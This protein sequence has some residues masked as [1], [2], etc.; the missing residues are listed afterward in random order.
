MESEQSTTA[1]LDRL[2]G[3]ASVSSESNLDIVGWIEDYLSQYG[4][5]S[6]RIP[7]RTGRKASILATIGPGDRPGVVLSAHTDVVPV[8]G[9]NWSTPPFTATRRDNRIIGRGATDMK[10]F[11]ASVLAHV[12]QFKAAATKTPI[13]IALSYDEEVGCRGAPD[14]VAEIASAPVRPA[15]CL[16]G[17]P[18]GLAVCYAHKGKVARHLTITGR[19]GHSALPHRG[20]NAVFAAARIASYLEEI[21]ESL[22][23]RGRRVAAFDPPY[24]TV[25]VGSL[26]GGTALNFVPD[27]ATLEFEIRYIPESDVQS[28]LAQADSFIAT[29]RGKLKAKAPEAD[30]TVEDMASYP[31]LMTA[32]TDPAIAAAQRL[33]GGTE[34]AMTVSFGTEAGLYAQAGIPT[35][36]CGPGDI[37]RAHKADE[38]IGIDE[39]AGADRMMQRLAAQLGK[40]AEEWI[41]R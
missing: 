12:P 14:L 33:A 28:M 31:A 40:P 7:D 23:R 17:E 29:E 21:A 25:H 5:A 24:T 34:P 11:I 2:I 37:G 13:H 41:R 36:V 26:H 35:V 19:G 1:I 22:A 3:F 9:Q 20:A 6:R 15:L 16:V 4:V 27:R 32:P 38:W 10:G 18:T 30:I 39:L 8:A